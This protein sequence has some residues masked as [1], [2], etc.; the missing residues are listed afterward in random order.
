MGPGGT[1]PDKRDATHFALLHA[2]RLD[3][4]LTNTHPILC[5][6]EGGRLISVL[7]MSAWDTGKRACIVQVVMRLGSKHKGEHYEKVPTCHQSARTGC[8]PVQ[9]LYRPS[10]IDRAA[11]YPTEAGGNGPQHLSDYSCL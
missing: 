1:V 10:A 3:K 2:A 6:K 7:A 5:R 11:Y 4:L 8:I 9:W